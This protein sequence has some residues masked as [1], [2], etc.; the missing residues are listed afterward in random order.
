M[1]KPFMGD[2]TAMRFYD[3]RFWTI[4]VPRSYQGQVLVPNPGDETERQPPAQRLAQSVSELE[5]PAWNVA[6]QRQP[7]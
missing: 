4:F 1:I 6:L 7:A 3:P 2:S 5:F